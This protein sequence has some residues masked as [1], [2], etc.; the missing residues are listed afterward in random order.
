MKSKSKLLQAI[1]SSKIYPMQNRSP[2][3]FQSVLPS[4]NSFRKNMT[5]ISFY[6]SSLPIYLFHL[7]YYHSVFFSFSICYPFIIAIHNQHM[8]KWDFFSI[9]ITPSIA[10]SSKLLLDVLLHRYLKCDVVS[11]L[12]RHSICSA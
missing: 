5:Q 12:R 11:T 2:A 10:T 4:I 6:S 9:S 8:P 1:I 3:I 7:R